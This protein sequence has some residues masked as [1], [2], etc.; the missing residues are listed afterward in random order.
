MKK[1]IFWLTVIGFILSG[2]NVFAFKT[3]DYYSSHI[4]S[5]LQDTINASGDGWIPCTRLLEQFDKAYKYMATTMSMEGDGKVW[6]AQAIGIENVNSWAELKFYSGTEFNKCLTDYNAYNAGKVVSNAALQDQEAKARQQKEVAQDAAEARRS[7]IAK[8]VFECDLEFFNTM[9]NSERIATSDERAAC[10]NKALNIPPTIS[11]SSQITVPIT[12]K[13][14]THTQITPKLDKPA[15]VDNSI[16]PA[17]ATNTVTSTPQEPVREI[18]Q[19]E[20]PQPV[21]QSE[22]KTSVFKRVIN[23]L[24]GWL[25]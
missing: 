17:I 23:F 2:S 1:V 24:F 16:V 7:A 25:W 13:P 20:T 12:Q 19:Q 3:S 22:Q 11:S 9:T 18:K 8:A 21:V 5:N 15:P 6:P 4:P 14:I 10:K